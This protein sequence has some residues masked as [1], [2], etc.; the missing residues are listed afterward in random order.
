MA[1]LH[2]GGRVHGYQAGQ[3]WHDPF[4]C[5]LG[6]IVRTRRLVQRGDVH[7]TAAAVVLSRGIQPKKSRHM[8]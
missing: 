3:L 2:K 7:T 1:A 6:L 4:G 8:L 5:S